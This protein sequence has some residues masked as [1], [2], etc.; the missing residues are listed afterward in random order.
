[1]NKEKRPS[2]LLLGD[3]SNFHRTLA[4][5]LRHLGCEVTVMSDGSTFMQCER[6]VD[7]SRQP[8]KLG[9][10]KLAWRLFA[11]LHNKMRGYDIVS[12]R[13][14]NF[15][16]LRPQRTNWFFRRLLRENRS[17]FLTALTT[18]LPFLDM[19]E[20]PDSPLRYSEWFIDGRPNR[21]RLLDAAQWDGWHLPENIY[22]HNFIYDNIDGAVS[23][24]Y[25]YHLSLQRRLP[26]GKFAYGGI[27]VDLE[28]FDFIDRPAPRKVRL[29][30]G[31]DR[32]RKLIKGSDIMEEACRN[33]V[34][35]FPDRAE[36]TV[37]ENVPRK[38]FFDTMAQ[39]HVVFD[40]IYSYTPATTA[41]EAMAM[42][43]TA[44]SGAE[45]EF[46]DFIGERQNFPIVNAPFELEPLEREIEKL[47]LDPAS[48]RERGLRSREFVERHNSVDTVARR[49]L[50]FWMQRL[51]Q[52][53]K[54]HE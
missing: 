8:G 44:V 6:D 53:E 48:L 47:V 42:G 5:G 16:E 28:R 14:P 29:F 17:V 46:Y 12:L 24:L 34:A 32:R 22:H 26:E 4:T 15:L 33:V 52:K 9:G 51:K 2:I 38:V 40:Q 21:L 36:L 27:P 49:F 41:L 30:I 35:R 37:V 50:D 25:E 1:M 23:A 7:I 31:R 11:P 54:S 13:D 39:C 3:Y 45:P 18:D 43:L 20:A 10:M 19:L